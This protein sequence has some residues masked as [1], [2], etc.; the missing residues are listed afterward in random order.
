MTNNEKIKE[1][2]NKLKRAE[3]YSKKAYEKYASGN[4]SLEEVLKCEAV[5]VS[6]EMELQDAKTRKES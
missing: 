4:G 5:E 3:K 6:I 2:K 1:L